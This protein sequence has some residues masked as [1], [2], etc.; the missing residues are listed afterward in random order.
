MPSSGTAHMVAFQ[1]L[2][3]CLVERRSSESHDPDRGRPPCGRA[4]GAAS[5]QVASVLLP[6]AGGPCLGSAAPPVL[7]AGPALRRRR[8]R[9]PAERAARAG[10]RPALGRWS[11]LALGALR[12][13]HAGR[14][15]AHLRRGP[16]GEAQV[17]DRTRLLLLGPP[18]HDGGRED[19]ARG[20]RRAVPLLP[21][22]LQRPRGPVP[23]RPATG[24]LRPVDR[25]RAEPQR[26]PRLQGLPE[27]RD[28]RR[29]AR[30]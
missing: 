5:D 2:I 9:S 17:P 27:P 30:C 6:L 1:C 29:R 28:P 11:P 25:R 18:G 19:G 20:C 24:P 13:P 10:C 26:H 22:A 21:R 8:V 15:L 4:N 16:R 7:G 3:R 23:A 12:R 14:V